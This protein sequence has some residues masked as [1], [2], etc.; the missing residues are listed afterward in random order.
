MA[1][2]ES[3]VRPAPGDPWTLADL[4]WLT[5]DERRYEIVDGS[6]V[7]T[8]SPAKP[9]YRATTRLRR[10]LEA[11]APAHVIVGE[12]IGTAIDRSPKR[13]TYLVPDLSIHHEDAMNGDDR[14]FNPGEVLAVVE[15][16]SPDSGGHDRITKRRLY[17]GVGI[18]HYW[19]VGPPNRTLT[20]LRHD[21]AAGYEEV[22][23]VKPGT[24]W[25]TDDPFPLSLDPADFT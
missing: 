10:L 21:G 4:H 3:L 14:A 22:A 19:I 5:D 12:N 8:P 17:A 24:T 13:T 15:V 11:Q 25:Q 16:L 7:V 18:R 20:V 6:L 23:I 1:M 2:T 9:H